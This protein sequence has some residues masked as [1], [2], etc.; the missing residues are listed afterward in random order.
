MTNRALIVIDL[1]NDYFLGGKWTLHEI[2]AAADNAARLIAAARKSGDLLL[3]VRHEFPANDA[4]FFAPGTDGAKTHSKVLPTDGET[5]VLK[6]NVNAF[7]ATELKELL[8]R[9]GVRE[10]TICGAMS[11]MCIDAAVRAAQDFGYTVTVVHDAC[12]SRDLEFNGV[13]VPA[14]QV[15]A[16]FMA[17]LDFG[18]AT[19]LSTEDYLGAATAN[20]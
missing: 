2:N 8:D 9:S 14:E 11:H 13:S 6:N 4:P 19:L 15:H 1:Q 12:A 5:V 16:A 20:R 17:A 10:V 3:H 7:R 18:Y